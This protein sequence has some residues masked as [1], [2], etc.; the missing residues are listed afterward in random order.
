[1]T[2]MLSKKSFEEYTREGRLLD[3]LG[4]TE[5]TLK[6]S[7]EKYNIYVYLID[8]IYDI[9]I[10]SWA[11][12]DEEGYEYGHSQGYDEGYSDGRDDY[13]EDWDE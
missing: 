8:Y 6:E 3:I 9:Y 2:K 11:S 7:Q 4:W 12:G 5:D 13:E 1:M 10:N